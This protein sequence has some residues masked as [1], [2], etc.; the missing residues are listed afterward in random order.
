MIF[1]YILVWKYILPGIVYQA[2]VKKSET[3]HSGTYIG[4]TSDQFKLRYRNHFKE[5]ITT[6]VGRDLTSDVTL[7]PARNLGR[8]L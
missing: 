6:K 2:T 5:G 3:K 7:S 1:F 4:L 8:S